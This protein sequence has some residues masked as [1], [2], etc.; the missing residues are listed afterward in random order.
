MRTFI[1][2]KNWTDV[3]IFTNAIVSADHPDLEVII[4]AYYLSYS[5]L[6]MDTNLHPMKDRHNHIGER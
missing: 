6:R 5:S 3:P 1:R 4:A 2:Y